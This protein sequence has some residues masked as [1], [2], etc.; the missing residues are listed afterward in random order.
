M[1]QPTPR[2]MKVPPP[3]MVKP[4]KMTPMFAT[5][6]DGSVPDLPPPPDEML[7]DLLPAPQLPPPPRPTAVASPAPPPP[8][9]AA[10]AA[11]PAPSIED[12]LDALTDIL[13]LSLNNSNDPSFFGVCAKCRGTIASEANCCTAMGEKYHVTCLTCVSCSKQL[14]GT[15]FFCVGRDTYCETCYE[16]RLEN[17]TKCGTKI[18]ERILK[19]IGG[20]FHP[21]CFACVCCDKN[22]DGIPFS[23]DAAGTVHCND[24]YQLNF[25]PRC[26]V[27][28]NLIMPA[29]ESGET[30]HIVSMQKNFHVE[31][32][33]CEDCGVSLSSDDGNGCYPLN[34]H[35]YC[36][37]CNKVRVKKVSTA[38]SRMST[39][40]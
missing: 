15:E 3:V 26:A 39:V 19:A 9:T 2:V 30:V 29:P 14:M 34:K 36:Q 18:T 1:K 33:R 37:L 40:L 12:E 20:S 35:L 27:C 32:Y 7:D 17:C 10:A 22:L 31:C 16:N 13:A 23:L 8:S 24:C 4:K 21:H 11:K 6:V 25:S 38:T 28:E 5:V